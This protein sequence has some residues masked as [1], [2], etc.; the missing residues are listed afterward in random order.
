MEPKA[1]WER[2]F[3]TKQSDE[4]S[5]YQREPTRSLELFDEAGVSPIGAVIDVGGGDSTLVDALLDRQFEHVTVL[6]I[7]AA[8]LARAQARLGPRAR[9]VTWLEADVTRVRL[10]P[11]GY[12]VWHDRA[13]FHF[14]IDPEDRARYVA[15]ASGA[16]RTGGTLIIATFAADGPKRCSGLDVVGY[17]P[18]GLAREFGPRFTLIRGFPDV[19]VTPR[20]VEQ[21]F[22]YALFRQ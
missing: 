21:R 17:S 12:D 15:V 3:S 6:D 2:V 11:G 9:Q 18:E 4:L 1:H 13:V 8:A 10:P 16:L 22:T 7:S 20:G 5:W 14:L 19:H